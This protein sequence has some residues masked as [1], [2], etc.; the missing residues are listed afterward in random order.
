MSWISKCL[1][2]EFY[3]MG[4]VEGN[5][6]SSVKS[7]RIK[8]M[9]STKPETISG[10]ALDTVSR[11]LLDICTCSGLTSGEKTHLQDEIRGNRG[12]NMVLPS[13]YKTKPLPSWSFDQHLLLIQKT[14][15]TLGV[16]PAFK[17]TLLQYSP[18]LCILWVLELILFM[19]CWFPLIIFID[20]QCL[21]ISRLK[22]PLEPEELPAATD[23]LP[24]L[25]WEDPDPNPVHLEQAHRCL[26]GEA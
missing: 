17:C 25:C 9:S 23:P 14:H 3:L 13:T 1:L 21:W 16:G 24:L 7:H 22:A 26:G 10:E 5:Q 12:K 8:T 19:G 15:F 4:T 20:I 11:G 18:T 2:F 6:N